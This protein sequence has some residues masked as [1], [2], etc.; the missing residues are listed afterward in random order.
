MVEA[1]STAGPG[2]VAAALSSLVAALALTSFKIIVGVSTGSLGILAEAA[3][4]GLDL[5]AALITFLAVRV[6]GK[7][8]DAGHTYGHGKIEN[9]SALFES[10]LLLVTCIWI[11]AEAVKRLMSGH[12][13]VDVNVWSFLVMG[14]SMVVDIS[15]SR[16]LYRAA[17]Q[18]SSQALEADALHF[19]TDIWSSAVVIIGL[20]SVKAAG[21]GPQFSWLRPADAI[22]ALG[23]AGIVILVS[24]RLGFRTV[25][26]LLDAAPAGCAAEIV[27]AAES[28]PGVIDCHDVRVRHSGPILFADVHVTVDGTL[29]LREAHALT[30]QI[31]AAV[32]K[33]LPNVDLVVHPEPADAPTPS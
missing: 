3:H 9:L 25:Q 15:R 11:I 28:V 24:A 16:M 14:T 17:K 21:W 13:T 10:L 12:V 5:V 20:V 6:S 23:V 8:A 27:A 26:A 33:A 30:E 29:P 7:P 19:E 18:Y 31:E 4:S 32:R 2:K 1:D 22:A